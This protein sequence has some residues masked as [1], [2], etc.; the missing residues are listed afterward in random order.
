VL[1]ETDA[2]A[3]RGG[4]GV[5]D[6][7]WRRARG[8]GLEQAI[9]DVVYYTPRVRPFGAVVQRTLERLRSGR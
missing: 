1:E 5:D 7:T 6:A 8:F 2:A 3:C 4:P 9:G